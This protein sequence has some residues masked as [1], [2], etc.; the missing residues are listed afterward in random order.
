M[1]KPHSQKWKPVHCLATFTASVKGLNALLQAV[2]MAIKL[3]NCLT[4]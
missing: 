3:I 1:S 4:R 2:L